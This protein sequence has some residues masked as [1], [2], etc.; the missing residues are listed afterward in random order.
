MTSAIEL[1]HDI[2]RARNAAQA[3]GERPRSVV[4][5]RFSYTA[6]SRSGIGLWD[7]SGSVLFGL[8]VEVDSEAKGWRLA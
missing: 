7:I 6:L 2:L 8:Q 1:A 4:L 5:D 3:R